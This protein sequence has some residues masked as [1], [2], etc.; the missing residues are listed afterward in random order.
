[1]GEKTKMAFYIYEQPAFSMEHFHPRLS[2]PLRIQSRP[3]YWNLLENLFEQDSMSLESGQHFCKNKSLEKS[4]EKS[5][6]SKEQESKSEVEVDKNNEKQSNGTCNKNNF[7]T[8]HV[9][10]QLSRRYEWSKDQNSIPWS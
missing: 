10:S 9:P 2:Q 5:S 8:I 7:K 6:S 1:M 4:E 3:R